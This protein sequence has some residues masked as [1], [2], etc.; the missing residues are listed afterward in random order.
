MKLD[1]D[2]IILENSVDAVKTFITENI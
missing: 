1:E 2:M